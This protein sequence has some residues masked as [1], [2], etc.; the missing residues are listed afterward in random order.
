MIFKKVDG[1]GRKP[2]SSDLVDERRSFHSIDFSC[3]AGEKDGAVF[4]DSYEAGG[5]G[6][7]HMEDNRWGK[8][9]VDPSY[10]NSL[11]NGLEFDWHEL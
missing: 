9:V 10:V 5:G 1:E 11:E 7:N 2:D 4:D 8:Q 6:K 3:Y